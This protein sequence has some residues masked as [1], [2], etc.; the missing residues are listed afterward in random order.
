[1]DGR[2]LEAVELEKCSVYKTD[3]GT[4]LVPVKLQDV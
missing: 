1:M 3:Q 2:V 4:R